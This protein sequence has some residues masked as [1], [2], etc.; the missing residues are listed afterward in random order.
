VKIGISSPVSSIVNVTSAPSER[1]IQ[2]RCIVTTRSG[3]STRSSTSSSKRC[4]YSVIL[5]NHWVRS[6]R[7]TGVPHRSQRP[8]ITCSLASTV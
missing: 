8:W 2:F 1:P 7:S 5:K 4:A 6:R 3:Q